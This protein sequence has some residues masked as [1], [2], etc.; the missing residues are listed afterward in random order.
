SSQLVQLMGG[1][2]WVESEVGRGSKFHF[3]ASFP[4]VAGQQVGHGPVE[5]PDVH[6]LRVLVVDD[7]ASHR[8]ILREMLTNWR[9]RPSMG[10]SPGEPLDEID[11]AAAAGSPFSVILLDAVMPAPD[12]FALASQLASRPGEKPA[13]VMMLASALRPA[14]MDRCREAGVSATVLKPIKQS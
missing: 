12:G 1:R 10:G 3:T 8:D 7:N 2:M 4:V 13:R 5:P 6:G 11:R 9:M 14:S